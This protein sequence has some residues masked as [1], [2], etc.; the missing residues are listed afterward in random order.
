MTSRDWD[1]TRRQEHLRHNDRT[2]PSVR[3][4]RKHLYDAANNMLRGSHP[5]SAPQPHRTTHSS[6]R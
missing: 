4:Q 2:P 1:R 3:E 5:D 6:P